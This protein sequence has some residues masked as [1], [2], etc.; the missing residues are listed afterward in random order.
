M[1]IGVYLQRGRSLKFDINPT[2]RAFYAACNSIFLHSSGINILT[3]LHLQD[4]LLVQ[5]MYAIR[6]LKLRPTARQIDELGAC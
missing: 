3:V 4:S 1:L 5:L 6:A 2:K